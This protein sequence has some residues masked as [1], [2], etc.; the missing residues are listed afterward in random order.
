[1]VHSMRITAH[2][3]MQEDTLKRLI[4]VPKSLATYFK[5]IVKELWFIQSIVTAV[6]KLPESG[7][8]LL[9]QDSLGPCYS[10]TSVPL[11]Q[12]SQDELWI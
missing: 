9:C 3:S 4:V 8:R 5:H 7:D 1:M 2:H 10:G 6:A 11:V 12:C